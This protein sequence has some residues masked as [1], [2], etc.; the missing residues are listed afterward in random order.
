MI[1]QTKLYLAADIDFGGNTWC[2]W[3]L[4]ARAGSS[5]LIISTRSSCIDQRK[6]Q[7]E[8]FHIWDSVWKSLC[9]GFYPGKLKSLR[10]V[11]CII[12]GSSELS[13]C[14]RR[15]VQLWVFDKLFKNRCFLYVIIYLLLCIL[16][17]WYLHVPNRLEALQTHK[18]VQE[19]NERVNVHEPFRNNEYASFEIPTN[20][21]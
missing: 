4:K 15:R 19:I 7:S 5:R 17:I 2:A 20:Y 9:V 6:A 16:F 14:D 18:H 1:P 10:W 3:S 12:I 11:T 8:E 21:R 13:W